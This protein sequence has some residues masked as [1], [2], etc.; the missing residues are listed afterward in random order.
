MKVQESKHVYSKFFGVLIA[1][2]FCGGLLGFFSFRIS[3]YMNQDGAA[4]G[5]TLIP[6]QLPLFILICGGLLLVSFIQYWQARKCIQGINP[7]AD[8][9]PE[10][11][12][13]LARADGMINRSVVFASLSLIAAFVFLAIL[14]VHENYAALAGI[15]FFILV[16]LLAT[17]MQVLP[18]NLLK[19]INPEKRGNPL[20]F[21][22]Q[23]IWLATSDEGEKFTLYQAAYK[24]YRLVQNVI[25]GLILLALVGNLYFGTGVFPV[26]LL[27]I[28]WAIQVI[29]IYAY[30]QKK[31]TASI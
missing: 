27:A 1:A 24:T 3:D 25:I 4:L 28:I 21:S 16:T 13:Q 18:I 7:E 5:E 31:G 11:E 6:L 15:G 8:L 29:A 10:D 30:S 19:K 20:D 14:E 2:G 9:S 26:L 22:F 23:K 17:V 12:G